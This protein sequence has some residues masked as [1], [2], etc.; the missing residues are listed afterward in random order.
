MCRA[1]MERFM[2]IIFVL[3]LVGI[4]LLVLSGGI[5]ALVA[6]AKLIK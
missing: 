4:T 2:C 5:A 3:M 6:V 1:D